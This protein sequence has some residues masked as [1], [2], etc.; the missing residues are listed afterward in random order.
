MLVK[1]VVII[2]GGSNRDSDFNRILFRV[3]IIISVKHRYVCKVVVAPTL[4]YFKVR[5]V[6]LRNYFFRVNLI[7]DLDFMAVPCLVPNSRFQLY[8]HRNILLLFCDVSVS[9]RKY[10]LFLFFFGRRIYPIWIDFQPP[11]VHSIVKNIT[12]YH[13]PFLSK[14]GVVV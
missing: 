11:F 10:S 3:D 8:V 14:M 7:Y 1:G 12:V 9:R 4:S 5:L 6:L 2:R 13:L